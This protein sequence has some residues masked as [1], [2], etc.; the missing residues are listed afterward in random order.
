VGSLQFVFALSMMVVTPLAPDFSDSLG[1]PPSY[2]GW[3]SGSFTAASAVSGLICAL[4]ID[5]FDRRKALAFTMGGV[6]VGSLAS[7]LAF[8]LSSLMGARILGGLFGGPAGAVATSVLA[9]NVAVERR[10]RAMGAAMGAVSI[11]SI[12]GVPSGLILA[13]LGGWRLP[14][15]VLTALGILLGVWALRLLPPQRAHL[16][17]RPAT[18]E[19][20]GRRLAR[21]GLRPLSL[22]AFMIALLGNVPNVMMQVNMPV[23]VTLNLGFPREWL[24]VIYIISGS[25]GLVGMQVAGRLVDR[26]GS[27][28]AILVI[29]LVSALLT[30]LLFYNWEWL[31]LPVLVL[32]PVFML[33]NTSIYV[34]QGAAITKVPAPADRAGFMALFQSVQQVA[35]AGAAMVSSL[36]LTTGDHGQIGRMPVLSGIAIALYAVAPVVMFL[37]ERGLRRSDAAAQALRPAA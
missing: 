5:R 11:A 2:I 27:S 32:V 19:H 6:V 20:P 14:F 28:A 4:F 7:A 33:F 24:S 26:F 22:L 8:N 12:V 29:A 16:A 36:V 37:L 17:N 15:F 25:L 30:Y 3:I 10:G 1:V 34:A 21:I 23:W 9:D 35:M 31:H 18:P 13:H